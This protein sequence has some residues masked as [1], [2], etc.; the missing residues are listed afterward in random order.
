[1]DGSLV[2]QFNGPSA[3]ANGN[4]V[5][6]GDVIA[7]NGNPIEPTPFLPHP[8]NLK[9]FYQTGQTYINNVAFNAGNENSN[10][11][12]SYTNLD[13]KGIMPNTD[14]KRNSFAFSGLSRI[15]KK[16]SVRGFLNYM[17]VA[18][19]NRPPL[20][21][22]S[23]NPMYTFNWTG[24][25]VDTKDLRDYWQAGRT[26]FNQFNSNYLWLD[27]PYFQAYENTNG[28]D[29]N[30][31]IGN[32][33]VTYNIC[34]KLSL[35]VRSGMD[36]HHDLRRSK[37]A[38]ST[39]R[40]ANGAYREDEIDYREINTDA[41]LTYSTP[42]NEDWDLTILGGGNVLSLKQNYTSTVANQLSVPGIYNFGNS[43]IPL[44][45]TEEFAEKR[46][47]SLYAFGNFSYKQF[48]FADLTF[49]N[50]WSS[51][52]PPS[53]NSY[54]YYSAALSLVLSGA[55]SMPDAI[56]YS[57]LR[58]SYAKVGSDADPYQLNNTFAFNQNYGSTPLLTNRS[59][60]LNPALTPEKLQAIEAGLEVYFLHDR[61]GVDVTV[62]QNT[63]ADQ[64]INLPT[65]TS[66]GYESRLVN[67]GK[68]QSRGVEVM[69]KAVPVLTSSFKWA[70]YVNFSHNRSRVLALPAGVD[71]YVTGFAS[72][73]IS[74]D[75][76]VFFIASS[77]NNGRVGDIYGTGFKEVNGKTVYDSKGFPVRDPVLRNLGNYNPDFI[78]GFGNELSYKNFNLDFLWDWRQGGV[79]LSR[80]FSLGSTSGILASTLP[81]RESGI[82]GDGVTNT[83]TPGDPKYTP[84]TVTISAAD[85]YG[86]TYNRVNEASS[87]FDASYLKLRQVAFSY[88]LPQSWANKI[89]V[90][91]IRLGV[92]A[93][94]VLL[95]TENENVDPELNAVQGR[96]YVNGVDD[97]SLPSSRSIGFN[98]NVN[99]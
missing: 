65:S 82:I 62:Y 16:I 15:D 74:S 28:F 11:R 14:L 83:G 49:R 60:L 94:N 27:N 34:D 17:N 59:R 67:G 80:T 22:G 81:G 90:N 19:A 77:Q 2:A 23:E 20:G 84:N 89:N 7:R 26:G 98:L 6:G 53:Q 36:Y 99:F 64:I 88:S 39:K 35:R 9:N 48:L 5:R 10:L 78:L 38:F 91:S 46:I 55:I 93:N 3:D 85:Y 30:R 73:Y 8:D 29:K 96:K 76:S 68:V 86:Q 4:E 69:L 79:F 41:L 24:R 1:M 44:V 52:L 33:S 37:R 66:S 75:N 58:L 40:F 18:S 54:A 32:A 92:I 31:L 43:K 47:N 61:L 51:A 95:F 63:N 13:N 12:L 72:V 56:S 25:Q 71:Q 45:S 50:D 97:M 57:K 70:S 87:I 21:Y 42:I